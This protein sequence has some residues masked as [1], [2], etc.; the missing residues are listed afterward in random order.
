MRTGRICEGHGD[1]RLEHVY[2][3][4]AGR[5]TVLD[6]IEFNERFRFI[7][8]CADVAFLAM[9][10]AWHGRVDLAERFLATYAR[11][12]DDY[13]LY[14]LVDF[15]E[16]YRAHVRAKI[17]T[18]LA[19]SADLPW[20]I[21]R[22]SA[23]E[24]RRYFLLAVASGRR[25][26]PPPALVAVGG[27]IASGKSTV[28]A[29]IAGEIGGVVVDAD[30]TRKHMLGVEPTEHV[31]DAAWAGA[32]DPA[33]T[34]R[35]Y[36]EMLRRAEVV[37]SSGRPVVIDASFRSRS[38]RDD[39]RS[40]AARIGVP[41]KLVECRANAAVCRERLDERARGVSVSDGRV[42]VWSS[43]VEKFEAMEGEVDHI[44]VDTSLPFEST[45]AVLGEALASWPR[46]LVG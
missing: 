8:T 23:E 43:F 41:W 46:G 32:Y 45:R 28:A 20:D 19:K 26:L 27:V 21:R 17:A 14:S 9:D 34:A 13:D 36:R 24:A 4:P 25:A 5:I 2:L 44:V 33:V 30:R 31:N 12:A 7:D 37:L 18:L 16:S 29:W 38:M 42:E 1:L 40:L 39:A 3:D 15:Y 11:E 22:R 10:L 35:V 6:C